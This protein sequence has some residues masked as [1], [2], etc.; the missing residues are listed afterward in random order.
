MRTSPPALEKLLHHFQW[1]S[2]QHRRTGE[3]LLCHNSLSRGVERAIPGSRSAAGFPPNP[4]E[5][6][7]QVCIGSKRA[8]LANWI[9]WLDEQALCGNTPHPRIPATFQA[10]VSSGIIGAFAES[11]DESRQLVPARKRS[12]HPA[13][14]S[15][16]GV[17]R[18]ARLCVH[19]GRKVRALRSLPAE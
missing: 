3:Y 5:F 16:D 10:H 18:D 12:I 4:G 6:P 2:A 15:N 11:S 17:A 14:V 1:P 8:Y 7:K 9:Y 13:R 19:R